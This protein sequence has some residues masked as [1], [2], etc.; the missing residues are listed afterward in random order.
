VHAKNMSH[1]VYVAP[2]GEQLDCMLI[3]FDCKL[4][5]YVYVAPAGERFHNKGAAFLAAGREAP[6]TKPPDPKP[7]KTALDPKLPEPAPPRAPKTAL[8]HRL[9]NKGGAG[10]NDNV[11]AAVAKAEAKAAAK[12]A[13]KAAAREA[14]VAARRAERPCG[15]RQ[16]AREAARRASGILGSYEEPDCMLIAC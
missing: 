4:K 1:Y 12:V 2:T 3:A 10:S 11:G 13:A 14:A 6:A 15:E 8:D 7:P 5:H 16:S 9:P